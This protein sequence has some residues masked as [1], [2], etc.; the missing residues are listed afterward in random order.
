MF[1]PTVPHYFIRW[2]TEAGEV[3]YDPFSGRGTTVLEA[4]LLG[5]VGLA[6]DASPLACT[7]SGAK[8]TPPVR[9]ALTRRIAALRSAYSSSS[10][11]SVPK[12]IRILFSDHTLRQLLWL[13]NELD[14]ANRTD[15]FLM[16]TLLGVLHL[17]ART[18]GTARGLSVAMPNTFSMAPGYVARYVEAHQLVPPQ[19]DVFDML[20]TRISSLGEID[21]TF[22]PGRVWRQDVRKKI[23]WPKETGKAALVFTSPPYLQVM[24]YGKLNW[25]RL[26]MLRKEPAA[27]DDRLFDSSSLPKY[28][29]FMGETLRSIRPRLRNDGYVCLVIGDVRRGDKQINL[30]EGVAEHCLAGTG[31]RVLDVVDDHLP[32]EH[33][34]SR[35]W[36]ATKGRATKVDRILILGAPGA[37]KLPKRPRIDWASSKG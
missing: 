33:K 12:H 9:Y 8:A 20:E 30:A 23:V 4:C 25:L 37:T 10:L 28:L 6:S 14:V 11:R 7:L 19:V 24:K 31:L 5:R 35:I 29:A 22:R 15:R 27:V 21:A 17:N 32:I 26:W 34:V 16:A 1:P 18:D 13:R 2:L 36:G 3:V